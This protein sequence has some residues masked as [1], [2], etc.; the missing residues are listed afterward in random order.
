MHTHERPKVGF[1]N[2]WTTMIDPSNR[3]VLGQ[4]DY[5]NAPAFMIYRL[6]YT[7]LLYE[8]GA[9]SWWAWS[10]SCCLVWRCRAYIM[11]AEAGAVLAIG[12]DTPR[13]FAP[14]IFCRCS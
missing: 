12:I 5:T 1:K 11:V 4:R 8:W 10:G 6:H 3:K 9:N 14:S 7:L 13:C 2:L